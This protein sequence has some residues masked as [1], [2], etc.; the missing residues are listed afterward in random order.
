MAQ[1]NFRF[2]SNTKGLQ[3]GI[4]RSKKQLSGFESATKKISSGIGK[5]LGGIGLALGVSALV[6]QLKSATQ[7]AQED[8]LSQRQLARQL[9]ISAGITGDAAKS[10][11]DYVTALAKATGV[12][13]DK[14]RPSLATALRVTGDLT[15]AQDLLNLSLD[16]SAGTGKDLDTVVKSIGRAYLGNVT[17]LQR[18]VPGIKKTDNAIAFLRK[19]FAGARETLA[20]PFAKLTVAVDEAQE[21]VGALLLPYV[22]K[23]VTFLTEQAIPAVEKFLDEINDPKTE[24]GKVFLDIKGIVKDIVDLLVKVGRSEEFKMALQGAL[25]VARLLLDALKQI[26]NILSASD[27]GNLAKGNATGFTAKNKAGLLT[28]ANIQAAAGRLG[29]SLTGAE[30]KR[31][32]ADLSGG[33]DGN[34]MT[35]WPFAKGGIV[36]P[37]PGGTLGV[38]GEA[39]KPEAVIPLDRMGDMFGGNTYIININKAAITGQEIVTAIQRYERGSGRKVLLNG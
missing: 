18:L 28:D 27:K 2:V 8:I 17:G 7:A 30:I 9:E 14:L 37:R 16:V 31:A 19:N 36:M 13:D 15:K 1:V 4:K 32:R 22:Q 33:A 21:K 26:D 38:I 34:P 25:G 24:A 29:R 35:P 5:A 3:D 23:F 39:G 11:E 12:S 10:T 20:D 6:T